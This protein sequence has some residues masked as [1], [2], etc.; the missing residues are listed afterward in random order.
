MI[1]LIFPLII[2]FKNKILEFTCM[3]D[4]IINVIEH[5]IG[6]NISILNKSTLKLIGKF[7][8]KINEKKIVSKTLTILIL[9]F[10]PFN[11]SFSDMLK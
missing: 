6:K 9:L 4:V 11:F 2:D 7:F 8:K 10:N 3:K 5:K 1:D